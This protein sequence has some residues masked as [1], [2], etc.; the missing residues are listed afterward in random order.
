M[1]KAIETEYNGCLYRSRLEARWAVFFD[2]LNLSFVYEKEGFEIDGERYLPDFWVNDWNCW[3]EIKPNILRKN[4][5]VDDDLEYKKIEREFRLCRKLSD[6]KNEVVM[7]IG[8]SPY[9][10][11]T[12]NINNLLENDQYSFNYEII[13]FYPRSI[14]LSNNFNEK[15]FN[16][17][18]SLKM[19]IDSFQNR[20]SQ[21]FYT[22]KEN[23][24]LYW[25]LE[26][27]Y[28]SN[29]EYFT[30]PMPIIGNVNSLIDADKTFYL[31]KH[32]EENPHWKYDLCDDKYVFK[33]LNNHLYLSDIF[34]ARK[35]QDK[36]LLNAYINAK[37]A[38]FEKFKE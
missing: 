22:S 24:S 36:K 1:I 11:G 23:C 28:K 15:L 21:G 27:Q 20:L 26:N 17:R 8:G 3:I 9:I 6:N 10:E 38:R 12:T 30:K 13:V 18:F 29:P 19:E 33:M 5:N 35:Y 25:F 32:N 4:H 2:S 34:N 37:K 7:L 31:K 16:T 14:M